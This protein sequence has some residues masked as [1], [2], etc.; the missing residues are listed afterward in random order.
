MRDLFE[1]VSESLNFTSWHHSVEFVLWDLVH[2]RDPLLVDVRNVP[3]VEIEEARELLAVAGAWPRPGTRGAE[4]V[5]AADFEPLHAAWTEAEAERGRTLDA[6]Q[7]ARRTAP[8]EDEDLDL[9]ARYADT[10]DGLSPRF[11]IVSVAERVH[12]LH[13]KGLIEGPSWIGAEISE[14]GRETLAAH[15][16]PTP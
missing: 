4:F 12:R 15:R 7:E 3:A 11:E 14:A 9:L 16:G 5:S 13:A 6:L 2:G 10:A 8:L 1:D